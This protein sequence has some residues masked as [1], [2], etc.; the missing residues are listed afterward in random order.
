MEQLARILVPI[1]GAL[2]VPDLLLLALGSLMALYQM[3]GL[4]GEWFTRRSSIPA[5]RAYCRRVAGRPRCCLQAEEILRESPLAARC[6]P[7]LGPDSD[8]D[9]CLDDLR[10]AMDRKLD[11]LLL[12]VRLGPMLGLAGTLI[13]LGPGLLALSGGD[14]AAL[15]RYLV[16]A[17]GSTVLGLLVSGVAFFLRT[18]RRAWYQQDLSDLEFLLDRL[19]RRPERSGGDPR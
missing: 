1:S 12:L 4:L 17:F 11:R 9:K 15:S 7:D 13:P 19:P 18:Q 6:L 3:G 8:V 2:L 16:V 14:V 10:L 5:H